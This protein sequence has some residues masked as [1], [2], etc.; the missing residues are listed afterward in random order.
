[1]CFRM[2]CYSCNG[3][4][5]TPYRHNDGRCYVCD[6]ACEI[7]PAQL[8]RENSLLLLKSVSKIMPSDTIEV[9]HSDG[10]RHRWH[11]QALIPAD[12]GGADLE[13][14]DLMFA[15]RNRLPVLVPASDL[16]NWE[17]TSLI[18]P[19]MPNEVAPF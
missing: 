15:A 2:K 14:V 1:M 6:G 11:K 3:T 8:D 7:G 10:S 5:M 13:W 17:A 4:G 12:T 19:N 16:C 9:V 18:C